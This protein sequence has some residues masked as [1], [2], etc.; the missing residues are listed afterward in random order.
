M[1]EI[2]FPHRTSYASRFKSD[3]VSK[4][5]LVGNHSIQPYLRA[6]D[7]REFIFDIFSKRGKHDF[8]NNASY[9]Y[10]FINVLIAHNR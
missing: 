1:V 10:I 4:K 2:L 3:K 9:P 7:K 5:N 6:N 8:G